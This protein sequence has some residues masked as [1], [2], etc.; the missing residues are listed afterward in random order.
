MR[1]MS[2]M[3]PRSP[4]TSACPEPA[5]DAAEPPV[6]R[7]AY[8]PPLDWR[9][10]LGFLGQRAIAG[11]EWVDACAVGETTGDRDESDTGDGAP[12]YRR[13][14]RVAG[15]RGGPERAGWIEV[16]RAGRA[17]SPGAHIALAG[18]AGPGPAVQRAAMDGSA[19]QRPAAPRS[20]TSR[21]ALV[22]RVDPA[23]ADALP[24]LLP[25]VRHALDLRCRPDAVAAALGQL[26]A[27]EE[28]LRLPGAFD[29]HEIG[30]RAILGQQI[31]VRFARV[32]AGR[33]VAAFG[34]P[35][36]TPWPALTHAFPSAAS[37]AARDP[38]EIGALGVTRQRSRTLVAFA[39]A[40]A[41]GAIDLSPSADPA[42]TVE[43]LK[44]IPGI[45]DWTAQYLAMRALRH[46]DAFPAAAVGVMRA[47]GVATPRAAAE[48]AEAFRPFRGYAVIH[49]WRSLAPGV[50]EE[51]PR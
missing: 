40:I 51:A 25:R 24:A 26:A 36:A 39:E 11:V 27:G 23:I 46:G 37:M 38:V 9:S 10:M 21:P 1:S 42:V 2:P 47:L 31:T 5:V 41:S 44:A 18:L 7:V 19:A 20:A 49:L 29:A 4:G 30:V 3:V 6:R 32:L 13:V 8:R 35:V 33:F 34:E 17:S 45:G 28:G 48:A 22:L 15:P 16:V 14:V 12:A 43:R 50:A